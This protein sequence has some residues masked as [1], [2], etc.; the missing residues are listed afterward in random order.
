MKI[1]IIEDDEKLARAIKEGLEKEGFAVD[2]VLDGETGQRRINLYYKDYD[3][4]ILDL[5]LPQK[6]GLGVLRDIRMQNITIPVLILTGK[7]T[8]EDI[9]RG[10]EEGADDYLVKPF[11]QKEL[12][13]RIK[14][15]MRRPKQSLPLELKIQDLTLNNVTKKAFRA[16][17]EIPLTL[18]EFSLLE[19][20]TRHPNEVLSREQILFN[21]WGFDF[22]SFSNVVDV[23]IKN[24]RKKIGDSRRNI[25]ETVRGVGYRIKK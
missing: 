15:L 9:I 6:D 3:L 4:V 22:D 25:L 1:L 21:L 14:A 2:F 11:S 20:L 23:H 5:M 17:K 24:L 16:N 10:L 13:A 12:V 19:Y 18:K 7:N 8:T